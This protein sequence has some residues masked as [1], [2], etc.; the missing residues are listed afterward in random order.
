M[1]TPFAV[2][3]HHDGAGRSRLAVIGE[4]DHDTSAGLAEA[5]ADIAGQDGIVEVVVDLRQVSFLAAAGVRALLRGGLAASA[6]GCAYRVVNAHGIVHQVLKV[7]G[8]LEILAHE[9][10]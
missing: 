2:R 4:L 8:V 9:P 10:A 1:M 5:I 7:S 3:K 6:R